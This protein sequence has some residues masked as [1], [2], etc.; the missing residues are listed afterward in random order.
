MTPARYPIPAG[1]HRSEESIL[2]S[3]F[4]TTVGYAPTVDEARQFVA[5][6]SDEFSDATHNCWAWVVGPPGS[7][8]QIGMSDAGEP[9]GTAGRPMLTVLL[10]SG[11]GDICAVVT[12][13]FGG[14][15]LGKGGLVRAYSGGVKLA[16]EGLVTV[17]H[18]PQASITIVL[19][20]ATLVPLRRLLPSFEA[21]VVAEE[22]AQDVTVRVRVP[23]EHAQTLCDAV[24]ELT[25]GAALIEIDD[26]AE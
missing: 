10:H 16:L 24:T 25:N 15:L 1:D 5:R 11:I 21:V 18:A 4:I 12:R 26:A 17:E 13:Y 23:L 7:S 19:D 2:R 20:Y 3:R 6:V 9:H 14:T 22:F 8:A